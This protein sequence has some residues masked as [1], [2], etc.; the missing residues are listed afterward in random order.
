MQARNVHRRLRWNSGPSCVCLALVLGSLGCDESVLRPPQTVQPPGQPPDAAA[1]EREIRTG[2][3][4]LLQG[5]PLIDANTQVLPQ[6]YQAWIAHARQMIASHANSGE[7]RKAIN[8][9]THDLEE[10]L[11]TVRNAGN[12]GYVL[13]FAELVRIFDPGTVK[14]QR[15]EE[16]AQLRR[17]RPIVTIRGWFER[18]DADIEIIDVFLEVYLPESGE[19]RHMRV[20]PGEEFLNLKFEKMIGDKKGIQFYYEPTNE[21]FEVYGP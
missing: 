7:G 12:V 18:L 15:H 2:L 9:V 20:R 14:V 1:I 21:V 4:P 16:W 10:A 8:A 19:S 13:V 11:R 5:A 3:D 17:N 6:N